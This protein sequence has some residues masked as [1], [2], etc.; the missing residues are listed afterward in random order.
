MAGNG[1]C[2]LIWPPD[3]QKCR[4]RFAVGVGERALDTQNKQCCKGSGRRTTSNSSTCCVVEHHNRCERQQMVVEP[5]ARKLMAK[6]VCCLLKPL[7][8][9]RA[10]T[11]PSGQLA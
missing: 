6:A 10:R 9:G 5:V 8:A 7:I 2:F 11:G 4:P 1:G 3:T